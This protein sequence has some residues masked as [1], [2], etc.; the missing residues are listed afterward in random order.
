[1]KID[2]KIISASPVV[3]FASF[4]LPSVLSLLA[5][6]SAFMVDGIFVGN[7]VG[8]AA[9]AAINLVLPFMAVFMGITIMLTVGA[10]VIC[11]K[12]IGEGRA[13]LAAQVFTK[14]LTVLLVFAVLFMSLVLAGAEPLAALLGANAEVSELVVTYIR[15]VSVF[16][17]FF[18]LAIALMIFVRVDGRPMLSL[19]AMLA[20]AGLNVVLDYVLIAELGL[21]IKGAALATGA[22]QIATSSILIVHLFKRDANLRLVRPKGSWSVLGRA[23]YNGFSEFVNETSAGIVAFVFNWVLMLE[24]GAP[25]V[26]SF[27]I[28][29]YILA[30]GI[31]M[32][33]GVSDALGPLV[34]VNYGA[35][36]PHRIK[37]FLTLGAA[38]NLMVGLLIVGV[39]LA[40]PK[41]LIEVFLKE[42]S[43]HT[44][45]LTLSFIAYVWPVFLF[46]GLNIALTGYFTGVQCARQSALVAITRALVLPI[47]LIFV[48]VHMFGPE[49]AFI[50][51]PVAEA[52]TLLL[53]VYLVRRK[54]PSRVVGLAVPALS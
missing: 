53:A 46:N 26:A 47:P 2:N 12:Y 29:N 41:V 3:L 38:T 27:T 34:S 14:A 1:M 24:F 22:S 50:A 18:A 17:P 37:Q 39:L 33:Y 49:G 42:G 30:I 45:A 36:K 9:L 52:L 40:Y 48:G 5:A 4:A 6:Q 44:T 11:G 10:A 31:M 19:G 32:S 43:E 7:Y 54:S 35:R 13:M 25:G 16:L 28:V 51:L 15:Y 8:P 23:A 21:G 20:G